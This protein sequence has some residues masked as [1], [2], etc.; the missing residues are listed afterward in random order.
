MILPRP[1]VN[2]R[3]RQVISMDKAQAAIVRR[4]LKKEGMEAQTL[5]D[6]LVQTLTKRGTRKRAR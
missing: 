2:M 5:L 6:A 4:W 3:G 1:S